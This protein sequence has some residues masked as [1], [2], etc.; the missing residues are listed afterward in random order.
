MKTDTLT[1]HTP[2]PWRSVPST[3]LI[4]AAPELHEI[5]EELAQW[6]DLLAQ[7]YPEMRG[8]VAAAKRAKEIIS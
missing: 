5:A 8:L 3:A 1:Q 6:H 4:A 2:G 7:N